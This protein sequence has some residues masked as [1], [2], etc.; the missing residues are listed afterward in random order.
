MRRI[1]NRDKARA[2]D[3]QVAFVVINKAGAIGAF[4]VQPGFSYTVS[5]AEMQG[6]IVSSASYFG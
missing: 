5:H 1:V 3:F 4:A 2:K 6:K